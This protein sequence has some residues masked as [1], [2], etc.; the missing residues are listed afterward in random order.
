M[1]YL[2]AN[3][4]NVFLL[5]LGILLA[6]AGIF[7]VYFGAGKSRKLGVLLL[8]FGIAVMGIMYWIFTSGYTDPLNGWGSFWDYIKGPLVTLIAGIAAA[9]V[10]LLVFIGVI[11]KA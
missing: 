4:I 8:I 5:V 6:I 2:A 7:T 10:A 3:F 9:V 11:T 1:D